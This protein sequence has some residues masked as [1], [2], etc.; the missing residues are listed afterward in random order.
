[1]TGEL[2]YLDASALVKLVVREPESAALARELERWPAQV[3]SVLSTVE[4]PRATA[5]AA[6]GAEA[7]E[8]AERLVRQLGIV[9]LTD[10]LVRI[11]S[12]IEPLALRSLDAIHLASALS[13][14]AA[15]EAF[16]TYDRRL[17]EAASAAGLEVLA[18]A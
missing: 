9:A 13:L 14:G 2:A 8:R 11:A 18:P 17:A 10:E 6:A 12:T 1:V 16:L 3:S 5:K 15:L 7:L 4:V